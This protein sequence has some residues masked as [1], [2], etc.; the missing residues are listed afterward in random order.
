M[1]SNGFHDLSAEDRLKVNKT[2]EELRSKRSRLGKGL[3]YA[4]FF[5]GAAMGLIPLGLLLLFDAPRETFAR[6][7]FLP[8]FGL[9]LIFVPML[10]FV[11]SG[12]VFLLRQGFAAKEDLVLTVKSTRISNGRDSSHF[13][14]RFEELPFDEYFTYH[15]ESNWRKHAELEDG[16]KVNVTVRKRS[17]PSTGFYYPELAALEKA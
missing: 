14:I 1:S 13:L 11:I 15:G 4:S 5:V 16:T 12:I 10:I 3:F 9:G 17:N 6:L 7:A 2:Q 8:L